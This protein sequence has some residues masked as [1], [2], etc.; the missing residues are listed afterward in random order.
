MKRFIRLVCFFLV[1][2]TFAAVPSFAQAVEPRGSNEISSYMAYC[3]KKTS[4]T[5]VVSYHITG[6]TGLD[7]IG[8]NTI[9]V[10][11]SS[12]G[13]NWTTAQTF[14]KADYPGMVAYNT[15]FHGGTLTATVPSGMQYRAYVEFYG[16]KDGG[17]T[18]RYYYTP[19]I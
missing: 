12:D 15:A 10:Q 5:V 3:T 19:V 13:V 18:E 4:T 9:K 17:F 2:A 16:E 11:Y 14:R 7:E 1:F 6:T 8:A